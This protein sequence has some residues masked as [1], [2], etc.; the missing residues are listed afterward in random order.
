MARVHLIVGRTG[1]GKTHVARRLEE[2]YGAV[3]FSIDDWMATLF[4][5]DA[6][7]PSFEWMMERIGRCEALIWKQTLRLLDLERDV[8]LDLGF[9]TREH[10][11]AF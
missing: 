9:S 6:A 3:R 5:P 10:R 7:E 1:V 2:E 4:L 8:I 11:K